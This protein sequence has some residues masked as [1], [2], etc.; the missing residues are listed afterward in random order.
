MI[1]MGYAAMR[2]RV[3]VTMAALGLS[4]CACGDD[5]GPIGDGG[6]GADAGATHDAST[7][8]GDDAG[9]TRD[10]SMPTGDDAGTAHDASTSGGFRYVRIVDLSND[11]SGTSPGVDIDWLLLSRPGGDRTPTLVGSS[12]EVVNAAGATS[13]PPAT[14]PDCTGSAALGGTGTLVVEFG[15]DLRPGDGLFVDELNTVEC[16]DTGDD[17]RH[18]RVEMSRAPDGPWTMVADC[19]SGDC[20]RPLSFR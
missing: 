20:T 16:P 14:G 10:A 2:L 13:E 19:T 17:D 6:P 15:D 12:A 9:A 5:R 4:L 7:S 18:Y 8:T 1:G 11:T 3:V